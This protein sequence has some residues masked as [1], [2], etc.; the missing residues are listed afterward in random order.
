MSWTALARELS[1]L[2]NAEGPAS[3][4]G[5]ARHLADLEV[6]LDVAGDPFIGGDYAP[7]RRCAALV[8]VDSQALPE[9]SALCVRVRFL[10]E[11]LMGFGLS[12]P[13][14]PN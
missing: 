11:T 12:C 5:L 9:D 8:L 14:A 2:V 1:R 4:S 3:H 7:V 13:G 6:A 10:A